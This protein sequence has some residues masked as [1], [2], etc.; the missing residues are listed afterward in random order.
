MFNMFNKKKVNKP[1]VG[2]YDEVL[3]G[4]LKTQEEIIQ[5]VTDQQHQIMKLYGH[6]ETLQKLAIKEMGQ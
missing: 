3:E 2:P 6:I 5:I 1:A 4:L